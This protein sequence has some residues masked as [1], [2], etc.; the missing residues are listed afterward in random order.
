M[1]N[2]SILAKTAYYG[3]FGL[4]VSGLI[5]TTAYASEVEA[6]QKRPKESSDVMKLDEIIVT[7]RRRE[8]RLQD[9]P[10]TA[11]ALGATD[12]EAYNIQDVQQIALYVPGLFIQ[13]ADSTKPTTYI[14]GIGNR[15][16][17]LGSEGSVGMFVDDVYLSRTSGQLTGIYDIAR[18]EVLKGPQGALFGRNTIGGALSLT[19]AS[20][21]KSIEGF[22]RGDLGNFGLVRVEGAVSGPLTEDGSL[23]G[24][25]AFLVNKRDGYAKNL[26]TGTQLQ[27]DDTVSIRGK[28]R[29][30]PSDDFKIDFTG[31]YTRMDGIGNFSK[32]IL[33]VFSARP[34]IS[35]VSEADARS[36]FLSIDSSINK[37]LY[38]A[39]VNATWST[40]DV[41]IESISGYRGVRMKELFDLDATRF[42]AINEDSDEKSDQYSQELR[43]KSTPGGFATFDDRLEWLL[44][45]I[46]FQENANRL[47]RFPFGPDSTISSI[48]QTFD[49]LGIPAPILPGVDTF[50]EDFMN[51][52]TTKSVA[53]YGQATWNFTEKLSL[54]AGLRWNYDKKEATLSGRTSRPGLPPVFA[55]FDVNLDPSWTSVDPK[56]TLAYKPE[57]DTLIFATFAK[58]TK[59]GG[60]QFAV[61]DPTSASVVFD[62]EKLI[63]YEVG[64]KTMQLDNRLSL[65]LSGFYYDYTNQQLLKI[66]P[67]AGFAAVIANAASSTIKGIEFEAKA[68]L[69]PGLEVGMTY[70]YLD[71]VFDSFEFAPGLD[72][73]GN[74]LPRAPKNTF[75]VNADYRTDVGSGEI[76]IHGDWNWQD[77]VFFEFDQGA[78]FGTSQKSYGLLNAQV[79][80]EVNGWRFALW[81]Q[82]LTDVTY[83]SFELNFGD[84]VS[85][86]F[87]APRTYGISV[88][89]RF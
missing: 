23:S 26:T 52:L 13:S 28:L 86:F 41:T 68:I 33:G 75:T 15:Q 80:Y 64:V 31:E 9:V 63:S 84:S 66:L 82:N 40:E 67:A 38:M 78:T 43:I 54:T 55:D 74:N 57:P 77:K 71:A 46:Y 61:F 36:E 10:V 76:F 59:S 87:G 34:G 47:D 58:G 12:I 44:G 65:A 3:L 72:F 89:S 83:T 85:H 69:L 1:K 70:A 39:I 42:N 20:P 18:V 16:F 60:F 62:P 2:Y 11:S 45:G 19:T 79:G 56:V 81:G 6:V 14:R 5:S 30:E 22:V 25:L 7:A 88:G 53:L 8:Q 49:V 32:P 73:S 27:A 48:V 17:D 4:T 21:T 35:L 51:D 29:Y 24:R 37:D 50:N